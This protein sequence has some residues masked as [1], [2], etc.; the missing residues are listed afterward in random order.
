MEAMISP[1]GTPISTSIAGELKAGLNRLRHRVRGAQLIEPGGVVRVAGP[2]D[3]GQVRPHLAGGDEGSHALA[4]G[5][6]W[7]YRHQGRRGSS[8]P[9]RF[10]ELRRAASP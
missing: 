8:R 3:D 10:Q 6:S 1:M 7:R 2:G 4:L 5:E 9:Q